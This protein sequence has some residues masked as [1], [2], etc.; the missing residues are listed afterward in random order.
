LKREKNFSWK[1]FPLLIFKTFIWT[2][3][4]IWVYVRIQSKA[5]IRILNLDLTNLD[6]QH[7]LW[8][9]KFL[10][11]ITCLG[12]LFSNSALIL[13]EVCRDYPCLD[14][15]FMPDKPSSR[16]PFPTLHPWKFLKKALDLA[17]GTQSFLLLLRYS[18]KSRA[19]V[20]YPPVCNREIAT[21]VPAVY[22]ARDITILMQANSF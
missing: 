18:S 3:I 8:E 10:T 11:W 20:R 2:Q 16:Y 7:G 6:S 13:D 21:N 9:K 1:Y 12:C 5:W 19:D 17:I 4:W 15:G 22:M 14:L